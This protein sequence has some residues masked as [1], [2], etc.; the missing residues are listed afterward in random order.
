MRHS[1][2]RGRASSYRWAL[3]TETTGCEH[4]HAAYITDSLRELELGIVTALAV[5]PPH[6]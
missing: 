5:V 6:P 4:G 2:A 3:P 1:T